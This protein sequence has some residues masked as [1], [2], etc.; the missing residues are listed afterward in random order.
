MRYFVLYQQ[1]FSGLPRPLGADSH[2]FVDDT[3]AVDLE[4]V[5]AAFQAEAMT[6]ARRCRVLCQNVQHLSMSVGDLAVGGDGRAHAVLPVG[7][8]RLEPVEV[9]E[10]A[11]LALHLASLGLTRTPGWQELFAGDPASPAA[12]LVRHLRGE[13]HKGP[14]YD[15][16]A[17]PAP[18]PPDLVP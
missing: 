3:T 2:V 5:F 17:H 9:S 15:L 16:A 7:F 10:K 12:E 13:A 14:R 6:E 11:E 1:V 4:E 18:E 8:G